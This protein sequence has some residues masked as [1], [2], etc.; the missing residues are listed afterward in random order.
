MLGAQAFCPDL[1]AASF[2]RAYG[3]PRSVGRVAIMLPR[4]NI[5]LVA[6]AV[7]DGLATASLDAASPNCV[8]F[9][10]WFVG[11]ISIAAASPFVVFKAQASCVNLATASFYCAYGYPRSVG[12][13]TVVAESPLVVLG[14]Q[15]F[16]VRLGS[17]AL[18]VTLTALRQAQA[19]AGGDP[20]AS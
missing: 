16:R 18:D 5:V 3:Y 7:R 10:A 12:G 2:N 17:A 6:Q 14:A 9:V 20:A 4:P 11:C 13:I 15:T 19:A 1:A 8:W